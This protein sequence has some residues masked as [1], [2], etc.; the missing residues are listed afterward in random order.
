[1]WT[2]HRLLRAI[3]AVFESL[4]YCCYYFYINPSW[5]YKDTA[6]CLCSPLRN[7]HTAV[8][9]V[10][11]AMGNV[12]SA[13]RNIKQVPCPFKFHSTIFITLLPL[14]IYLYYYYYDNVIKTVVTPPLYYVFINFTITTIT[15]GVKYL[16]LIE[17][18]SDRRS[19]RR[20]I[21][22]IEEGLFLIKMAI[23]WAFSAQLWANLHQF[24][25]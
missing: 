11:S 1:M 6:S 20:V 23:F 7:V 16:I 21:E 17:L 9:N 18:I 2:W 10:Y 5:I 13:V 14:S 24:L 3:T 4:R 15:I 19:D 8:G 12:R 22:V 25:C